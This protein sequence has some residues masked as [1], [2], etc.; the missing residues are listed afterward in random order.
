MKRKFDRNIVTWN[1]TDWVSNLSNRDEAIKQNLSKY[2]S[3]SL[4]ITKTSL[5]NWFLI[6]FAAASTVI[7]IGLLQYV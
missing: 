3:E 5:L 2:R 1:Q 4:S 6:C 7:L